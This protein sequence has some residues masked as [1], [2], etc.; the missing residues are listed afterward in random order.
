[1]NW[2]AP[3]RAAADQPPRSPRVPLWA[4]T[5]QV[6]SVEPEFIRKIELQRIPYLHR[7]LLKVQQNGTTGWQL[8]GDPTNSLAHLAHILRDAGLAAAWRD[9]QLAVPAADGQDGQVVATVERAVVRALGITTRAVHLVGAAPDGRVWVQQ[10]AFTKP[11]DPGL[12]DTLVGGMVSAADNLDTALERE[13]WEEAGLRLPSLHGL[14]LGGQ[15][16]TRR[17]STDSG[18]AGYV[19]EHIHWYSC[20]LPEGVQPQNQDGEVERFD[21]LAPALLAQQLAQG[22]FTDDAALILAQYLGLPDSYT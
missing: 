13:T 4:G 10:R 22:V 9:E 8:Q 18:G 14:R 21:L 5:T 1:M 3:L 19:V 16:T 2:L 15:L 20:T 17:P 12:W 7:V 11:N 6:G